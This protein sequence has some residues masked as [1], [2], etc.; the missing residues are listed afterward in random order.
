MDSDFDPQK[1]FPSD[2]HLQKSL[3]PI[4]QLYIEYSPLSFIVNRPPDVENITDL[5]VF[6]EMVE[7]IEALPGTYDKNMT[8]LWLRDYIHYD[9]RLYEKMNTTDSYLISY[10]NVQ[11]FLADR[12]ME[13]KNVVVYH[14]EE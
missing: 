13:D 7:R 2:S 9:Q 8:F 11:E 4:N 14:K 6:M 3:R 5:A 12:M 1:T 10:G